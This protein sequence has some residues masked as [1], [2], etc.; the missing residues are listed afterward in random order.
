MTWSRWQSCC[1]VRRP[2]LFNYDENRLHL[3]SDLARRRAIGSVLGRRTHRC[4]PCGSAVRM[5]RLG[6]AFASAADFLDLL[7]GQMLDADEGI[8]GLAHPN[9]LVQLDLNGGGIPV[10]CVLDQEHHQE[11]DDGRPCVD[12]KLPRIRK[13]KEWPADRP[14]DDGG[15]RKSKHPCASDL[16]RGGVGNT[17]KEPVEGMASV[18]TV[19]GVRYRRARPVPARRA[20]C[21]GVSSNVGVPDKGPGR[22]AQKRK[23]QRKPSLKK[24]KPKESQ[25]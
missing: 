5:L 6:A 1:S 14:H 15:D 23:A 2:A 17:G 8:M 12:D 11:G 24:A 20:F 3:P 25:A 7:L 19:L 9:E 16:A 21:H 10:L 22:R 18:R 13:I 4:R